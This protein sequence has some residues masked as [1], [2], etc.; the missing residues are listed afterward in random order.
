VVGIEN[1]S[2][3]KMQDHAMKRREILGYAAASAAALTTAPGRMLGGPSQVAPPDKIGPEGDAL[4]PAAGAYNV[5]DF[6]ATGDGNRLD[7]QAINRTIEVCSAAGGGTVLFPAGIYLTGTVHLNSNLTLY[8]SAGATILGSKNLNDYEDVVDERRSQWSA[9]FRQWHAALLEGHDLRNVAITGR[10]VI[11][12][13]KVFDPQG[14]EK[15]RGPHAIL[16]YQCE[17]ISIQD[18]F[19]KDAANYAHRIEGCSS[20][21]MR[22]VTV[23]GGWDGVNLWNCKDFIVTDCHFMSGD[24]CVSGGGWERVVVANCTLNT[25]CNGV[26]INGGGSDVAFTN[27]VIAGPGIYEHRTSGRHDLLAGFWIGGRA[28]V[29]LVI[30]NVSVSNARCPLWIVGAR[31]PQEVTRNVSVDN[32]TAT[33]V[34]RPQYPTSLIQG[35]QDN[36]I[37]SIALNNVTIVSEGGGAKNLIGKPIPATVGGAPMSLPSYGLFCRYIKELDLHNVSFSYSEKDA[38]PALICE[39]VERLEL[40]GVRGQPGTESESWI[41]LRDIKT[42]RSRDA[43]VP[44][45]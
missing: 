36:P 7:T 14:E 28:V 19:V 11:D 17:G 18:I 40:D 24:D 21:N 32:L 26:R 43:E 45:K 4:K 42:L 39:S 31:N 1:D 12:G 20:G 29:N 25:S 41:V 37:E 34:G 38:R 9:A 33:A 6:G 27:L 8:L 15:M 2:T 23:T 35:N 16:F 5:R 22:G 30:S 3:Y 13:N 44:S 10:G